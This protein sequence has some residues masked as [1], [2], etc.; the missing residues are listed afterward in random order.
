MKEKPQKDVKVLHC[1]PFLVPLHEIIEGQL[2]FI[3]CFRKG[4][5][6][7]SGPVL[8]L[9]KEAATSCICY[10]IAIHVRKVRSNK[11]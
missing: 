3:K 7:D 9:L 6:M 2:Y 1:V 4:S 5:K 10:Y 11:R 8:L